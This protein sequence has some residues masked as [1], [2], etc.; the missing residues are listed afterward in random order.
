M[1]DPQERGGAGFG[2]RIGEE[3]TAGPIAARR[4][5]VDLHCHSHASRKPV[6]A[7]LGLLNV[8]ECYSAPEKVYEQAMARGMDLVTI[9][10]HDSIDGAMELVDRGFERVI[11]GEEVTVCFPED[12]CKLH[13]LVWGLTAQQHEAIQTQRLREDVYALAAW[14]AEQHLP[15]A[16]AHPLYVQNGKLTPWHL[17]RCALLFKGWETLNGAHS[18]SHRGV[19]ERFLSALTPA[20]MQ[21][22]AR[23]HQIKPLWS[24][25]WV[26]GVTAGSDDHALLNVGR[27]WTS[28]LMSEQERASAEI[29]GREFLRRV[30]AGHGEVGGAPG[31]SSLLA[32]QLATVATNYYARELHE[33]GGAR[34]RAFGS[35]LARFAGVAAPAPSRISL[36][37]EAVGRRILPGRRRNTLPLGDALR[38][39]IGP[40]L[41]Q[42]PGLRSRLNPE[43]WEGGA[44]MSE[45]EDMAAFVDDLSDALTRA[46]A[47]GAMQSLRKR[48]RSGIVDHLLSYA[49]LQAAQAP[50]VFSL[51]HQNKE[52]LMLEKIDND[53][54]QPG[55]GCGPL[56]RPMKVSLFTD[57]LGDVNGVC[58]F[59]QNVAHQAN[60]TGRDLQVITSTSFKTPQWDNIFNFEPVFS[61]RMPRYEQLEVA[62]PP[63][64][65]ML[66]H[67]DKHQPDLIHISTPGPVGL[68]GF[69]AARM[70]RVP[71]LGVYHTDFPA[72]VDHLFDDH[73][74][75]WITS[76]CMKAFYKPFRSVFTRSADYAESLVR[77]GLQRERIVR[78]MPGIETSRFGTQYRDDTIWSRLAA[79]D[80]ALRG[81]AGAG[82]KALYVGRVS[83]EKNLPMLTQV[84]KA[85]ERQC[86]AAGLK[87]DLVIVGDGPYRQRMAEELRGRRAHF[88]GF[89]HGDELSALYASSDLFV[90]PST[91]DTLGQVVME[92]QAS[93]L[94]VL[95]T[96]QGGPK[97]V[98]EH[99]E[100]GFVLGAE[101]L[102]EWVDAIVG[103]V[104]DD[105]R[106]GAMGAQAAAAMGRFDI[107]HSF[108]NFW[109][110]HEQAWRE[111]LARH[112]ITPRAA[113]S[114]S[115]APVAGAGRAEPD[116][117]GV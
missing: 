21:E 82:V 93:G 103:L 67:I 115:P 102:S 76:T 44:P 69:I 49:I 72:Y 99:G 58:R 80:P 9:T 32:H 31:H 17:E 48:D 92:S 14:L 97:E 2:E 61:M 73:A 43:A 23:R 101:A 70:L 64:L 11:V 34:R 4:V 24:R 27:T 53:S 85:V 96:D 36:L 109:E 59:I 57:T 45:H 91:T 26:K 114:G 18:G 25:M 3:R 89:R 12:G 10:D 66:R 74:L 79:A 71:V 94:P 84:W 29:C 111:H 15:H 108:E 77:L 98:V 100:T 20:R 68:I 51:F 22:L 81:L 7:A 110:V 54:C 83:V 46:L 63:M 117:A 35:R 105:A 78:L 65:R 30:M 16:L 40:L 113:G 55:S 28:A 90:F 86:S 13:V 95:V 104:R 1:S 106:R 33:G 116:F 56:E 38:Q 87:A 62:L 39:T 107:S 52:R 75:T 8:P 6:T 60:Q 50:Y 41:E 5:R 47:G 19:V 42:Y 88:L 37:A 112:G